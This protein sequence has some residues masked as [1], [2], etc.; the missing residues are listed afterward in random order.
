MEIHFEIENKCLLKCKH[1]SSYATDVGDNME[2]SIE[3]ILYFL[4][5]LDEKKEKEIF[6]TGGEP[7]LHPQIIEIIK[8]IKQKIPNTKIGLFTS[9]IIEEKEKLCPLS[10]KTAKEL[11]EVG[12]ERCYFSIYS[13]CKNQHDWMTGCNGSFECTKDT[14]RLLEENGIEVRFNTVVTAFNLDR[15]KN[16]IE[17]AKEWKIS[18]V[19]FL[20]L[21]CHG[22]ARDSWTQIGVDEKKYR[23][24]I[25]NIV[26][27]EKNIVITASGIEDVIPCRKFCGIGECPA[28]K[29]LWYITYR[30]EIYP[31]ASVKNNSSFF[32][33]KISDIAIEKKLRKYEREATVGMLCH[34]RQDKR[35]KQEAMPLS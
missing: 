14:I 9:G 28:G 21:I 19:R 16:I 18:E 23:S 22:R 27:R 6:L 12:L 30:G 4:S 32:L 2:Y 15:L 33:G 3:D 11:A 13:D 35:Q 24:L 10:Q 29:Q 7:L 31:C 17:M 26:K 1:C 5:L 20:K 25:Q 34:K 8:I